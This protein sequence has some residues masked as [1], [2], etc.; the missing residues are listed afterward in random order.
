MI[1][2][3][4]RL[5]L[6]SIH[7]YLTNQ[8]ICAMIQLSGSGYARTAPCLA[9]CPDWVTVPAW[10]VVQY[11]YQSLEQQ[12]ENR[13]A[14]N[15]N[16][17]CVLHVKQIPVQDSVSWNFPSTVVLGKAGE[18]ALPPSGLCYGMGCLPGSETGT[19]SDQVR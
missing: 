12:Q 11:H 4:S 16:Y 13:D 17:T 15:A 6:R 5:A 9:G 14:D 7:G 19:A 10:N 18:E 3:S 2:K 8:N 1:N